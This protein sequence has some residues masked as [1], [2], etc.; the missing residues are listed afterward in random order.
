MPGNL[1]YDVLGREDNANQA[2]YLPVLLASGNLPTTALALGSR[3]NA[4]QFTFVITP[5]GTRLLE[6]VSGWAIN[7][8]P[9][10]ECGFFGPTGNALRGAFADNIIGFLIDI[11]RDGDVVASWNVQVGEIL[12]PPAS[13]QNDNQIN[14]NLLTRYLRQNQGLSLIHI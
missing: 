1:V 11:E 4:S 10:V 6:G 13:G 7:G 9:E 8:N 3:Y 5:D 14:S 2:D 12:T